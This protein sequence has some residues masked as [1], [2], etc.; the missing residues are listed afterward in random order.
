MASSYKLKGH[1]SF[2]I[3]EGWLNKGLRCIKNDAL[4]FRDKK[5]ADMLGVGSNMAQSIRYW[6]KAFKLMEETTKDGAKLTKLGQIIEKEDPY[7]EDIF[8]LWIL[9]YNLVTHYEMATSWNLLFN[10]CDV[11]D[12]SREEL[13][14]ELDNQL[15]MELGNDEYPVNSL[16]DDILVLTNMYSKNKSVDSD[17]EENTV[18]PFVQLGLISERKHKY[19]KVQPNLNLINDEVVL[20]IIIKKLREL[21][22]T[23]S[24][25]IDTL[26]EESN[27]LGKVLNLSRVAINQYLD[28]LENKGYLRVNRTAGLDMVYLEEN[29]TAFDV[30]Q[31]YYVNAKG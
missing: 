13:F 3:R 30:I 20:Y 6:L 26:Y 25:S 7:F 5:A 27:G 15:K 28:R 31:S 11:D 17:P 4:V 16:K 19:S 9:H 8:T 14:F 22:Y 24:I 12:Y 23:T 2:G 10:K 1:G 21:N 18:S 29:I